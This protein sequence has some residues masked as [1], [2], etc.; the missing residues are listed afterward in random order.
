MEVFSMVQ[1][2]GGD[3]DRLGSFLLT[4]QS[5]QLQKARRRGS[6]RSLPLDRGLVRRAVS[7]GVPVY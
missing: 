3:L 7:H 5:D 1:V 4:S 6:A 2:R